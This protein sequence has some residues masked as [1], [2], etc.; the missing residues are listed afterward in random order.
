[1]PLMQVLKHSVET[2]KSDRTMKAIECMMNKD[3]FEMKTVSDESCAKRE[4][5]LL[6]KSIRYSGVWNVDGS[7]V[8]YKISPIKLVKNLQSKYRDLSVFWFMNSDNMEA[9]E[10]FISLNRFYTVVYLIEQEEIEQEEIEEIKIEEKQIEKQI[11]IEEKVE[12][13]E[14]EIVEIE[15]EE[16]IEKEIE[17]KKE[18]EIKIK[19][20]E[21][22]KSPVFSYASILKGNLL[23]TKTFKEKTEN[24]SCKTTV[25]DSHSDSGTLSTGSHET[26]PVS[27]RGGNY[28]KTEFENVRE[29]YQK[30]GRERM[31]VMFGTR[32][33]VFAPNDKRLIRN[34]LNNVLR[35]PKYQELIRDNEY[36]FIKV[37]KNFHYDP[38]R[39]LSSLHF[40]I[41]FKNEFSASNVYHIYVDKDCLKVLRV[42]VLYN[43][44]F[45]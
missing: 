30:W 5:L 39:L 44:K 41:V 36:Y 31:F 19:K 27:Y 34:L 12:I 2:M 13:V 3:T 1:M 24:S 29:Y 22:V 14:I 7:N 23:L 18:E 25:F 35:D 9:I 40:N 43:D 37:V 8:N 16:I 32:G 11:E 26:I 17:I 45:N 15:I 42:S 4:V 28:N 38:S 33:E 10:S 20:E 21:I 6:D